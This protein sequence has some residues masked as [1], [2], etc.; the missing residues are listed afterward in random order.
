[1]EVNVLKNQSDMY[2]VELWLCEHVS[3]DSESIYFVE[4]AT[5][6]P[7]PSVTKHPKHPAFMEKQILRPLSTMVPPSRVFLPQV[8]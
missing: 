1:M 4:Q 5:R 3:F 8:P 7:M 6:A 2:I